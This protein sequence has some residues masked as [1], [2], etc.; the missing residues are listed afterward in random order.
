MESASRHTTIR[1]S[2]RSSRRFAMASG[3]AGSDPPSDGCVGKRMAPSAVLGITFTHAHVFPHAPRGLQKSPGRRASQ[4]SCR[5]P[6]GACPVA[7]KKR[8]ID[9][10]AFCSRR[11]GGQSSQQGQRGDGEPREGD[12]AARQHKGDVGALPPPRRQSRVGRNCAQRCGC[13][14]RNGRQATYQRISAW[15]QDRRAAAGVAVR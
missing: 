4:P 6:S 8:R 11:A 10:D 7:R 2:R 13:A 15:G 3:A 14:L 12:C 9:S 5:N 1:A